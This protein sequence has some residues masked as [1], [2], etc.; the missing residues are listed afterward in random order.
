MLRFVLDK[1]WDESIWLPPNT[2]WIDITPGSN[3]DIV[4]TDYRHLIYALPLAVV[5]IC[6][7]F[8]L[9]KYFFA[10]FGRSLG[11]KNT[12]PKKAPSNP[13]LEALCALAKQ[14]DMSERQ[15]E[16]WWRLRRSQ[17]K[18]STLVK[19]CENMWRCTFYLYNFSFGLYVLWDKEW[20][21]N[22]W[23]VRRKDFWQMFVHHIATIAL[24]SFSWVCNIYRIG[25]LIILLHDCAD[26]FLDA[27]KAAKY[28]AFQKFCDYVFAVF[29]VMEGDIR[30]SSSEISDSSQ[31]SNHSTPNRVNNKKYFFAPFGRSLGINNTRLKKAPS[32]PKLE[33]VQD[34]PSTLVKFCEN[35]WAITF[36]VYSFS[37]GLY[38]MWDKEW[39]WNIDHCFIGYPH[40]SLTG[41]VWWYYM[42][43][44]AFYWALIIS[45][46]WDVQRKDFWQIFVHHNATIALL[47]FSW[48]CN[49]YRIGTLI[50][51]LHDWSEILLNAVKAAKYA[52]FQKLC[53]YLFAVF[54]VVWIVTRL[55]MY[56]F[57][58]IWS[59]I[60]RAPMVMPKFPACFFNFL[61]C[62]LLVLHLYWTWL[63][64]QVAYK[65]IRSGKMEGDI[66]SSSSEIS[67]SSQQPHH[68]TPIRV[69]NKK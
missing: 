18:P 28:A 54:T 55:G 56:P 1:F 22:F 46:F 20:L 32:N 24:L 57:Y 67:D 37:F 13:K 25:S 38:V 43:I 17:D 11:I 4:Y 47:S 58:I 16:R 62:L 42:I 26:I 29:T 8:L 3:K 40:Q 15:V 61:L 39:L 21:W 19:F 68:S 65:A 51:L 27:G 12:R 60:I 14:L 34:K 59:S 53:D 45:Q 30:S 50:V 66:R 2:T 35:M 36:Y 9:E 7:R 63:I 6:L 23:D 52:A 33:A 49:I 10:P 64:F 41:D 69:N 44:T 5:L 48:V 31:Q